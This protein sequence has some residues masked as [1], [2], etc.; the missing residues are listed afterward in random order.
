MDR[1][2][3]TFESRGT[4]CAAWLYRP[5]V[6]PAPIVVMAH[7]F[8]ATR[9]LR[10]D[11][12]AERFADAGLGVL[13][14]DYRSFG[15]SGGEPR[16]VVSIR[17]Q[18]DDWRAAVAYARGLDWVDPERLAL[19]GSSFSGG[20]VTTLAAEDHRVAALVAQCPFEDGLATLGTLHPRDLVRL[21]ALALKDQLAAALGRPPV[22]IPAVAAPGEVGAM[23][24]PDSEP[25]F[26]ALVPDGATWENRVAAR[27]V[28]SLGTYR[29]GTKAGR[30]TCPGLWCITDTDSLCPAD[31]TARLAARAP[32]AEIKHYPIGHF[33]IYVGEWFERAVADQ[34]DFLLRHLVPLP[35]PG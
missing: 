5:A 21:V 20:H 29:P 3:V 27:V 1:T 11:A 25:G 17:A 6:V 13:L 23:T 34:R 32:R 16:Q 35:A 8:S 19:F 30:I 2:D 4:A 18:L 31:R 15:A 12:Y 24:T 26:R 10:L 14:F 22:Y 28:L 9:E 7:G 33:D